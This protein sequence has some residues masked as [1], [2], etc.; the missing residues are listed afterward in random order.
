MP[1]HSVSSSLSNLLSR[2]TYVLGGDH[3]LNQNIHNLCD[4]KDNYPITLSPWSQFCLNENGLWSEKARE[5][6]IEQVKC[7]NKD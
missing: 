4:M 1:A 3:T 6:L 2:L 5:P 7:R